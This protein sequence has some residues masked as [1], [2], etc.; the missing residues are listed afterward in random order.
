MSEKVERVLFTEEM[1][2]T[3]TILIPDML[4]RHFKLIAAIMR[5]YGYKMELLQN[6]GSGVTENGLKYVHNDSCYPAQLVIGQFIDAIKSGKYDPRNVALML[7]QTGGGCRASN[8]I[9]LLRKAL[10]RAG[11]SY[12]PIIS[13]NFSGLESNPGFKLTLPILK[14]LVYAILFGDLMMR[15]VNQSRPYEVVKGSADELADR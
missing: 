4:P 11:Y 15:L 13:L 1:R 10:A 12:I 14:K 7:T 9:A 6:C 5:N 3:H 2:K 8:Y